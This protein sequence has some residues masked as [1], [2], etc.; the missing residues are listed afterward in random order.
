MVHED[1]DEPLAEF[2]RLFSGYVAIVV[3]AGLAAASYLLWASL[4]VSLLFGIWTFIAICSR[5][6]RLRVY[7]TGVEV[8]RIHTRFFEWSALAH[9][10]AERYRAVWMRTEDAERIELNM[11]AGP[12]K[13][14]KVEYL[15]TLRAQYS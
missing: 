3:F 11:I 13:F 10:E 14:R 12:R 2:R 8:R 6:L 4:A 1:R 9:F 7:K 5:R 15:N